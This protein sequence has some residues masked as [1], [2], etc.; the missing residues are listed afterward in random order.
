MNE[1][2][3]MYN[4]W[5][6]RICVNAASR[7]ASKELSVAPAAQEDRGDVVMGTVDVEP[8]ASTAAPRK[9]IPLKVSQL[10]LNTSAGTDRM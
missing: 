9:K 6:M 7:K 5:T 1:V 4:I 10:V 3:T 8:S 2:E